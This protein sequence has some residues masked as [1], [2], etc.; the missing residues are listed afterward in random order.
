MIEVNKKAKPF[1]PCESLLGTDVFFML[2]KCQLIG[3]NYYAP[4]HPTNMKDM[5]GLYS[6]HAPTSPLFKALKKV[7]FFEKQTNAA[8]GNFYQWLKPA[9]LDN[10]I[11]IQLYIALNAK[12]Y[13]ELQTAQEICKYIQFFGTKDHPLNKDLVIDIHEIA[14]GKYGCK[15]EDNGDTIALFALPPEQNDGPVP[16]EPPHHH[17]HPPGVVQVQAGLDA[18]AGAWGGIDHFAHGLGQPQDGVALGEAALHN[19]VNQLL[20]GN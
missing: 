16:M 19:V 11:T 4:L 7:G 5:M 12:T 1:H 3:R 2:K 14:S 8:L 10:P 6:P 13:K 15:S 17:W 20:G 9:S 18:A